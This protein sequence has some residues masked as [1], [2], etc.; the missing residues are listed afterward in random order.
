MNAILEKELGL[1]RAEAAR[2]AGVSV[3]TVDRWIVG[4]CFAVRR[5]GRRVVIPEAGFGSWLD[6]QTVP[7]RTGSTTKGMKNVGE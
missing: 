1:S 6:S 2:V 5:Y 4:R 3:D 7:G